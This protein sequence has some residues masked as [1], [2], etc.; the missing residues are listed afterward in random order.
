LSTVC[1]KCLCNSCAKNFGDG[2]ACGGGCT[3]SCVDENDYTMRRCSE[4]VRETELMGGESDY[5]D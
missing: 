4:Y 5:D 1:E 3:L 2:S